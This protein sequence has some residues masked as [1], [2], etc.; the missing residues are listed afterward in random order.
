MSFLPLLLGLQ[1]AVPPTDAPDAPPAA[2]PE[3][4]LSVPRETTLTLVHQGTTTTI[5]S[6]PNQ[7]NG[8]QM[9]SQ[10]SGE[11]VL[12]AEPREKGGAKGTL[13]FRNIKSTG[14]TPGVSTSAAL[15]GFKLN[16]ERE[17]DGNLVAFTP[18][19]QTEP[20]GLVGLVRGIA[21]AYTYVTLFSMQFPS[22]PWEV[23]Q[24]WEREVDGWAAA[25][26]QN[27]PGVKPGQSTFKLKY[28]FLG[29]KAEPV[30]HANFEIRCTLSL[31]F[32]TEAPGMQG[33]SSI[34]VKTAGPVEI[35]P[36][37]GLVT[38]GALIS[39]IEA[40]MGQI[41]VAQE[42]DSKFYKKS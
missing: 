25:G 2:Q 36:S 3:I 12:V 42:S 14:D 4:L 8:Y 9:T 30:Y 10:D 19:T 27:L 40:N 39:R 33:P 1:V 34:S 24:T 35:D 32:R 6:L 21:Q 13:E 20:D 5:I 38:G 26:D 22:G 17:A 7:P 23:G 11:R 31:S 18:A 15:E 28:K 29:Y 41:S 37:T 16:W